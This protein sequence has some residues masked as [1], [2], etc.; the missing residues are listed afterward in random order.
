MFGWKPDFAIVNFW[1]PVLLHWW[2]VKVS[3]SQPDN[4]SWA[5]ILWVMEEENSKSFSSLWDKIN[6]KSE[7]WSTHAATVLLGPGGQWHLWTNTV[8]T[9][10]SW[11]LHC[12]LWVPRLSYQKARRPTSEPPTIMR[13]AHPPSRWDNWFHLTQTQWL[14]VP[15]GTRVPPC[16]AKDGGV[17][18]VAPQ[19]LEMLRSGYNFI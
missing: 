8:R 6:L 15:R 14:N 3:G 11:Q 5:R 18:S 1:N 2:S 4:R 19:N 12:T 13:T 10:W 16:M 7:V 9:H 17:S